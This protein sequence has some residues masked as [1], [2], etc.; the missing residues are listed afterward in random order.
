V[1]E[2]FWRAEKSRNRHTGGGLGLAIVRKIVEA[3]GG[4]VTAASAPGA[5]ATFTLRL[6]AGSVVSHLTCTE[7]YAETAE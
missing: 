7:D 4:A 6:P 3:H 1:F 2:R 5:G